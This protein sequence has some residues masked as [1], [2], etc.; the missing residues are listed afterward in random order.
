MYHY[1]YIVKD[2]N[3]NEYYIGSRSCKCLPVEDITYKGSMNS[4]KLSKEQKKSLHKTIISH[5]FISRTEAI[6]FEAELIKKHFNEF[7]YGTK[8]CSA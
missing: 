1:V 3:T 5:D 7:Y 4:W 8:I 2:L 6:K